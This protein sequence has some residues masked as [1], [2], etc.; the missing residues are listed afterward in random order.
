MEEKTETKADADNLTKLRVD[1]DQNRKSPALKPRLAAT[2][3]LLDHSGPV[4]KVLMGRRHADHKFMPGKFVFPGGRTEPFD[5]LMSV[6]GALP[7]VVEEKLKKR[8]VKL[9]ASRPKTLALAAL[10]ETFEETGILIG[11]RGFAGAAPALAE[12]WAAFVAHGV[13]PSLENLT[14]IARA[15]TPPGRPR[16][17]DAHFFATDAKDIVHQVEGVVTST[18]ELVELVWIP[19]PEARQ[20]DLPPI[21]HVVLNEL[22]KRIEAGMGHDLPVPFYYERN[23]RWNREEL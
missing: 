3:I 14:F 8:V 12:P 2:L 17:F 6:A 20:L 15:I 21:T 5:R 16:R 11:S 13:W 18:S 22:D 4:T 19:L 10:R 1:A 23:K 9:S 7:P